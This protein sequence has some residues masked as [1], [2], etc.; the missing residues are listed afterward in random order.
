VPM[1]RR[2][3]ITDHIV[4]HVRMPSLAGI[5]LAA[6]VLSGCATGGDAT[7]SPF[8]D[9]AHYDLYDC[10]QLN[11]ARKPVA[12]RL[13][14]LRGLMA[15]AET[16]AAGSLVSGVA[17]QGDFAATKAQLDLIDQNRRRNNCGE[18]VPDKPSMPNAPPA[19]RGHRR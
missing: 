8:A 5:V 13:S 10:A 12:E 11:T 16:G 2:R 4:L 1:Q 15:K 9:P 7:L 17:Y 19:R 3:P 14:E 6:A 18:V